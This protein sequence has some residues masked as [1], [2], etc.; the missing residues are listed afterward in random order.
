M[1]WIELKT[2][3]SKIAEFS[4]LIHKVNQ[5]NNSLFDY[6]DNLPLQAKQELKGNYENSTGKILS[7]R[8]K[9]TEQL[10]KGKVNRKEIENEFATAKK[11]DPKGYTV[12]KNLFSILYPFVVS[13]TNE[14][15]YNTLEELANSVRHDLVIEE[16]TDIKVNGFDGSRNTGDTHAWFAIY[17]NTYPN[18]KKANQLF[19]SIQ[20]GKLFCALYDRVNDQFI[21]RRD[22][23]LEIDDYNAILS[24]FREKSTIILN[25]NYR[26]SILSK[27]PLTALLEKLKNESINSWLIKPGEKGSMWKRA[28]KEEN[29]R[30]G[31]GQVIDDIIKENNYSEDFVLKKLTEHYPK[32]KENTRQT[33][34]K[35]TILSFLNDVNSGDVVF[36]VSGVSQ[37]IGVG[38]IS[39][40]ALIDE[41]DEEFRSYHQVDWLIDLA[42]KP[43][44][45]E[46]S[47]PIKTVTSLDNKLAIEII[48]SVFNSPKMAT[49]TTSSDLPEHLNTILYGPPG[50]G[51]T[52]SLQ[53]D[54][55]PRFTL[56][57]ISKSRE[58]HLIEIIEDLSWWQVI[59]LTL[60]E[61]KVASVP[62]M[63]NHEY[64][65]IKSGLSRAKKVLNTIWQQLQA[66]TVVDSKTVNVV[67]R[68]HPNIFD[69]TEASKWFIVQ[70]KL[71][72][73]PELDD[74][75]TAIKS[76][77]KGNKVAQ[78]N[79]SFVTF[80]QSF[81]YEDFI[82]GIK[83]SVD[84]DQDDVKYEIKKGVFYHACEKAV[85]L[86]GYSSLKDC[87]DDSRES[88]KEKLGAAKPYGFFIDEINRANI[89]AVFGELITLI[90]DDKR[91]GAANEISDVILP[92][93]KSGFGVPVN[94][95]IIGTMNTADR[96][97]EA[98]DTALRRRFSF[99]E[100]PPIASK[101]TEAIN[102]ISLSTLLST[103]N[104]RIEILLDK[105]HQIGHSFFVGVKNEQQLL[106]AFYNKIIPL[107]QEFFYGDYGKI[108]LILDKGFVR[109]KT[110]SR[111]LAISNEF[112]I[113]GELNDKRIF[114]IVDY[115]KEAGFLDALTLLLQNRRD[116]Q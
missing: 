19:F 86:A 96:S 31:W 35:V 78:K 63:M 69:K 29:I 25:D 82:E 34:N 92:Y 112:E 9:V 56:T 54:Y 26:S 43:Y 21:D 57:S 4:K 67:G 107:L 10:V 77:E 62:E 23:D 103:I 33:N 95:Q 75:L 106:S 44:Q 50:T 45:P 20:S 41:E 2:K 93:S 39:S 46:Y 109:V 68:T 13:T 16:K 80:H 108:G 38:V 60:S 51:K 87:L 102:D 100:K 70:E 65:K 3:L 36:A 6:L 115:R 7:L 84:E 59:A 113:P 116:N 81:S 40:E 48:S 18:Q 89:S 28:L 99:I 73:A 110:L 101:L 42:K 27:Y 64:I 14:D 83:P 17:N 71:A 52:F 91:L 32:E 85:Q 76:Y 22:I 58:E 74:Y 24:F 72:S 37:I 47:L 61:M 97:V 88:R 79:Y 5:D 53:T 111:S 94:L 114:E 12:Y 105:D 15:V 8:K 49:T 30:I 90:E 11:N 98:L 55:I 66:H 1:N 104:D